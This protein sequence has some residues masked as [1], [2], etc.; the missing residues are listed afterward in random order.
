MLLGV[1][2]IVF[3][4]FGFVHA[5]LTVSGSTIGSDRSTKLLEK[6]LIFAQDTK[7]VRRITSMAVFFRSNGTVRPEIRIKKTW[8][9]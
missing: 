5:A 6:T 1:F 4:T 2:A 7:G 8:K 9:V 3:S